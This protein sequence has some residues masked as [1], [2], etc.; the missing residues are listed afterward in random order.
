MGA[1]TMTPMGLAANLSLLLE[2]PQ[3]NGRSNGTVQE[4]RQR[5]TQTAIAPVSSR[6]LIEQKRAQR[7]LAKREDPRD[8]PRDAP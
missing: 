5:V 3:V 2:G 6:Q 4:H 1:V 7:A 8:A